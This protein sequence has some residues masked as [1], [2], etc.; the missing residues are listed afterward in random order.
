[1]EEERRLFFVGMTR[2]KDR[3]TISYARHRLLRG[4]FLRSVPSPFLYEIG[5]AGET[6]VRDCSEDWEGTFGLSKAP[7]SRPEKTAP[8]FAVNERVEHSKFGRGSVKEF[9]DLG[10]DSIVVV[11]FDSGT[12]KSLMLKYAS[13]VKVQ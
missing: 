13:L 8:K 2:A 10:E 11:R 4:Q 6:Q 3:L 5:F 12:T 7:K 9:L 1:M